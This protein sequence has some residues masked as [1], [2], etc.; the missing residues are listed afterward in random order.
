[1]PLVHNTIS[2]QIR[3]VIAARILEGAYPADHRLVELQVA[4]EFNVSQGPVREAF[5]E[6]RAQRLISSEPH[7]G[8]Y[9]RGIHKREVI[10]TYR[11]RGRIEQLACETLARESDLDE[12][13]GLAQTGQATLADHPQHLRTDLAFHRWIVTHAH[14]ATLMWHWEQLKPGSSVDLLVSSA[15]PDAGTFAALARQHMDI[16]DALIAGDRLAAG[17]CIRT[18]FEAFAAVVDRALPEGPVTLR[19]FV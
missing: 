2:E 17:T 3:D 18:H 4:Q 11:L 14:D 16:V 9:V 15:A 5:R 6:L 10:E 1:M 7:R 8:T 13:R 19:A 12:L